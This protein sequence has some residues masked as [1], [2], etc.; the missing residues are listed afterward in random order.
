MSEGQTYLSVP[1]PSRRESRRTDPTHWPSTV[2]LY[3]LTALAA[4]PWSRANLVSN[5]NTH[6]TFTTITNA[7]AAASDGD[8]LLIFPGTYTEPGIAVDKSLTLRGAA[9]SNTIV[10]AAGTYDAASSR[11]FSFWSAATTNVLE[12]LTVRHG[13]PSSE[14]GEGGGILLAEGRLTV[15][16]CRV[17]R[18]HAPSGTGDIWYPYGGGIAN[19]NGQLQLTDCEISENTAG[20]G[21]G[22][23]FSGHWGEPAPRVVLHNSTVSDN[24][25]VDGGGIWYQGCMAVSNSTVSCNRA[26][27]WGG[28]IWSGINATL[29]LSHG[30]LSQNSAG[31]KGGGICV[32]TNGLGDGAAVSLYHAVVADN[33]V[34]SGGS[35]PDGYGSLNSLGYNFIENTNNCV[36]TNVVTGNIYNEDP[37]L[38]ALQDNGGPTPTHALLPL[39]PCINGGDPGF[40][41]PPTGDQRGDPRVEGG[42]IDIGAYEYLVGDNLVSNEN[43][44]LVYATLSRA[45]AEVEDG[46]HL[47]V[48]PGTYTEPG[49]VVS[50][51]LT[52]RGEHPSNTVVQ[53]ATTPHSAH[54]RVFV[55]TADTTCALANLTI[56]HGDAWLLASQPD[57]SGG[58]IHNSGILALSNCVV[59]ANRAGPWPYEKG[60]GGIYNSNWG[61][62]V[63]LD[64]LVADNRTREGSPP[65]PG[66][67]P[68][69]AGPGG[70][71]AGIFTQGDVS[72]VRCTISGNVT[73]PGGPP[74]GAEGSGG[75]IYVYHPGSLSISDST[76]CRNRTGSGV[77]GGGSGGGILTWET[78]RIVMSNSTL[79]SNVAHTGG[80]IYNSEDFVAISN[81]TVALNHAHEGG[82][83]WSGGAFSLSHTIV[84][85]NTVAPGGTGP[86]GSA[87][88]LTLH[89]SQIGDTNGCAFIG[90]PVN[91][92]LQQPPLLGPLQDNGGPTETHALL[93]GSPAVNAGGPSFSPP[94]STDQRGQ[95][96]V[97]GDRIDMGAFETAGW[98]DLRVTK[99]VDDGT[100]DA[101]STVAYTVTVTNRGPHA[102]TAIELVDLLPGG[103]SYVSHSGG[104]YDPSSG[105]WTVGSLASGSATALTLDAIVQNPA[106]W[107]AS[108]P[109]P[110]PG[111]DDEFGF[112]VA[113]IGA[114]ALAVGV[115]GDSPAGHDHEG[116]IYVYDS[117]GR[118]ACTITN[119]SPADSDCFGHSVTRLGSERLVAGVPNDDPAGVPNAGCAYLYSTNG[120]FLQTLTHPSGASDDHFGWSGG[121]VTDRV[122]AVGVPNDDAG[123][124]DAG[125]VCLFAS[126]G[127]YLTTI[128]TPAPNSLDQFGWSVC[129]VG[130]AEL[131]VGTPGE[132]QGPNNDVGRAYI[133]GTNGA[134]L[135]TLQNPTPQTDERFGSSVAALGTDKLIVGAPFAK[136]AG[137]GP[138]GEVYVFDVQGNPLTTLNSPSPDADDRFGWQ[139]AGL[140]ADRILV[141][142]PRDTPDGV[143]EVGAVYLFDV[144]GTLLATVTNPTP[145]GQER[146][147]WGIAADGSGQIAVAAPCADV[148][149]ATNAGSVHLYDFE[150]GGAH[151]CNTATLTAADQTDTNAADDIGEA[152]VTV[153]RTADLLVSK[154][155]DK[156]ALF[157][158]EPIVYTVGVTNQGPDLATGVQIG[159]VLPPEVS[160]ESVFGE[161]AYTDGVWT[162]GDLASGAGTRL[163]IAAT[164]TFTS[165]PGEFTNTAWVYA[166]QQADTNVINDT[167]SAVSIIAIE[168]LM[169]LLR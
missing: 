139:V 99:A 88:F 76:I 124:M 116:S 47:Y 20:N 138:V 21:G 19:W 121:S 141:G 42:V 28:G 167:A 97:Q 103:V 72:L 41:P 147:G 78:S 137:H 25:A 101:G 164:V 67:E 60:G 91:S 50:N 39:S 114:A 55:F 68:E 15:N 159:D 56:R 119:P 82:G 90:S 87:S 17:V 125:S 166:L 23:I 150:I 62:L 34:D 32:L 160:L 155:V 163:T 148:S 46:D 153:G 29:S 58:G 136:V 14:W 70:H 57:G 7:I 30:T 84:A 65:R 74:N 18:N 40:A 4:A 49:I 165:P 36:I 109:N 117:G 85:D 11:V 123:A 94:P 151:I 143:V 95:P 102:G 45:I 22:G 168:G 104:S 92:I 54:D 140:G 81:S 75:G 26:T 64:C 52:M 158:G 16:R 98:A 131:V 149:G 128:N 105:V 126:A 120:S 108:I 93:F 86:D 157:V 2:V 134:L 118:L 152:W 13:H 9:A 130:D 145:A 66:E 6:A 10:Q 127:T 89:Y 156:P 154:A 35:G 5:E 44:H 162:I 51:N 83:L 24:V 3:L 80:G 111:L 122:V 113:R 12:D 161:G 73:G 8:S 61:T 142:A 27:I 53:A 144:T 33:S 37:V 79:S 71:G 69:V 135:A 63:L 115:P 169:I 48:F 43:S 146:F 107:L 106:A 110:E 38:G 100:P 77:G 132:N 112:S 133:Y 59:T 96:R 1:S 129:G 31:V